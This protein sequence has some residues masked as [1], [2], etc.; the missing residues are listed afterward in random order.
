MREAPILQRVGGRP[1]LGLDIGKNLDGGGETRGGRH[2]LWL[3]NHAGEHFDDI[4]RPHD[5]QHERADDVEPAAPPHVVAG[6]MDIGLQHAADDENPGQDHEN[7]SP[8]AACPTP[9]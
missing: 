3:N 9:E 7:D 6:H 2:V 8:R 1:A 4:D 5:H